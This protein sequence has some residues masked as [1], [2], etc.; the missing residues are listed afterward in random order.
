MSTLF[1]SSYKDLTTKEIVRILPIV[2]QMHAHKENL[3]YIRNS[4]RKIILLLKLGNVEFFV[5]LKKL[6]WIWNSKIE[7]KPFESF[8]VGWTRYYLPEAYFANTTGIE[9]AM[10]NIYYL[11]FATSQS[12]ESFN[13][14]IAILCRPRRW[15]WWFRRLGSSYDG[16]DR[17]AYN[18]IETGKVAK[19]FRKKLQV[20]YSF[21][22]LQY[23]ES[24][25]KRFM[26]AYKEVFEAD[27]SAKQLFANG[28]G[29]IATLEDVAK[30][31]VHGSFERVCGVNAHTIWMYLKHNKIKTD[32]QL[33]QLEKNNA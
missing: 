21:A 26:D 24:M 13:E 1:P 3:A 31:G 16:E 7:H 33:R 23:F 12:I 30:D 18:S 28:E 17:I 5:A 6:S 14:L 32:E 29:W 11:R 19:V 9:L 15:N 8:R 27:E 4:L 22:V 25:N 2:I 10:A 20:G